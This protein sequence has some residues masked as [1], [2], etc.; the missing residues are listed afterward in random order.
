MATTLSTDQYR[1]AYVTVGSSQAD[2]ITDGSSDEVEVQAAVDYVGSTGG[3]V[4]FIKAGTYNFKNTVNIN[5]SHVRLYGA[6]MLSTI[7]K[8]I[9]P[10]ASQNNSLITLNNQVAGTQL[11]LQDVMISDI[12]LDSNSLPTLHGL[13]IR[14]G[15]FADG[16]ST[17]KVTISRCRFNNVVNTSSVGHMTIF[18][19]RGS[20]NRGPVTNVKVEDCE[21]LNT[22]RW[23]VYVTGGE[24]ENLRFTGC[25]FRN[26]QYGCIAFNQ[27]NKDDSANAAVR[28][29][30]NWEIDHCWFEDNQLNQSPLGGEQFTAYFTDSNKTGVRGLKFHHNWCEGQSSE[31]PE[32][33]ALSINSS[34]DVQVHNNTFWKIRS[35]FNIGQS[36]N[37]PWYQNDG[38]QMVSI[39]DNVFFRCYNLVDHDADFFAEFAGN[40]VIECE[41]AG[42]G[43]YSRQW[44]SKIHDNFFYNTPTDDSV[45]NQNKAAF[46]CVANG[47][48]IYNNTVIDDRL[49]PDPTTAP[50]LSAVTV[51]ATGLGTRTYYV[52]QTWAN[53]TG[54]TL[55]SAEASITLS[56]TQVLKATQAYSSTY[57][58]PSG[59]KLVKFYVSTT[60]NVYTTGLQASV[61]TSWQQETETVRTNTHG[62]VDW[63]EPS[64]GLVSG[65]AI[66][67]SNTTNA[68]TLYGIY[69][70]S[71][72]SG[73]KYPNKYYNNHF[74]GIATPINKVSTYK[75]IAWNNYT[76]F[77]ITA[78]DEKLVEAIP[79]AQGN[80][81]GATTFDVANGEVITATLTG[82][83]TTTLAG[84]HYVGQR[85]R[86]LLTQDGTGSRTISKPTNARLPGGAFS[87]T[88]TAAATDA[89][90]LEW[91]GTNWREI[92]RTLNV[93]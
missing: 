93:S 20:V 51:A 76:N 82:N 60:S 83:V 28:S 64:S 10:F 74:Y 81:T 68:I 43:G 86:L 34:W 88:A 72:G 37:G 22:E 19:G 71:G 89:W 29:N 53:D 91:D 4:V 25:A 65:T 52:K 31:E 14:G 78:D 66:P 49:L 48:E 33:Y 38:S 42:W 13:K 17:D 47:S 57:G 44:A 8:G 75:R 9:S 3:G 1:K 15:D 35:C 32:Q 36:N 21:F 69:E 61:P 11:D 41:F 26:S 56:N 63:T 50:T 62:A 23:H 58:P 46:S 70:V 55:P 73:P 39:K 84:G 2:Y 77:L 92:S 54:E 40:K 7:I 16:D 67:Q 90:T 18:S 5:Y 80:V 87:P 6:G 85:L 45:A 59:A 24:V 27:Q 79:Y 30:K 12:G